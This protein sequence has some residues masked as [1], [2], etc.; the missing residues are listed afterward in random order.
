MVLYLQVRKENTKGANRTPFVRIPQVVA[1]PEG[2]EQ[3]K[4]LRNHRKLS[5]A[6]ERDQ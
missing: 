1:R 6:G 2:R 3:G 5:G 4:R